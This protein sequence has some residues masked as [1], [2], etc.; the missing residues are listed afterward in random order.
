MRRKIFY[1][2]GEK[3]NNVIYNGNESE[4][5]VTNGKI[6]RNAEFICKCGII[7]R[8]SINN[9]KVGHTNSCGCFNRL[10]IKKAQTKHGHCINRVSTREYGIWLGM[11]DRC[12]NPK[13]IGFK[14]YGGRGITVCDRWLESFENFF[15]D[16]GINP[17]L[18]H[19]LD[20]INNN[21][22]YEPENCRWATRLQQAN[23]KRKPIPKNYILYKN[24]KKTLICWCKELG[25]NYQNA[26]YR[27]KSGWTIDEAL[28]T[29]N[30]VYKKI[31][32]RIKFKKG[33]VEMPLKYW[34]KKLNVK[35]G[36]LM[37][38]LYKHSFDEAFEWYS[39]KVA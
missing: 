27:I 33:R 10:M 17:S 3:I 22:N 4:T 13:N 32:Y 36:T 16:M 38:F 5:V 31:H 29:Q 21:G 26:V 15:E 24:K 12:Y 25:I 34:A 6:I 11:K 2:V 30:R 23:N 19:S 37:V 8:A 18:N 39:K 28:S 9:V 7:F 1:Q 20:R 14:N 35:Y